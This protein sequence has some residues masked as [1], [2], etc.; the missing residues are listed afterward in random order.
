[1]H[2][3]LAFLAPPLDVRVGPA[4]ICWG[5]AHNFHDQRLLLINHTHT[6][7]TEGRAPV[8]GSEF[9]RKAATLQ[10]RFIRNRCYLLRRSFQPEYI[11]FLYQRFQQKRP[12]LFQIWPSVEAEGRGVCARTAATQRPNS[13]LVR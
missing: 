4:W 9:N 7:K 2:G 13:G 10:G 1:L 3:T 5:A 8:W 11:I 12:N 6:T